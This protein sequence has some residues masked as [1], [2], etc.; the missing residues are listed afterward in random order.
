MILNF[1]KLCVGRYLTEP[2]SLDEDLLSRSK[3]EQKFDEKIHEQSLKSLLPV[4]Q[5]LMRF[6][7]TDRISATQ[8]LDLLRSKSDT[9]KEFE[10]PNSDDE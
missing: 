3:L 1:L 5:G 6:K 8:A 4:I 10:E 9:A 7:P 2:L